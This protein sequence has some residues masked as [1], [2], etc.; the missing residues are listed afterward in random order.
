MAIFWM[1]AAHNIGVDLPEVR[2]DGT[3]LSAT[4]GTVIDPSH[5]GDLCCC[6]G[7]EEFIA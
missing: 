5:R 1:P 7:H 6:T 3:H 2:C 4:Y